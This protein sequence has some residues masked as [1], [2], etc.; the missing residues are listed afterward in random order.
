MMDHLIQG[1]EGFTAAYLD[2]LVIYSST[3]E[4]HLKH[5]HLVFQRLQ[6]AGLTAKPK[7]CQF[8]MQQC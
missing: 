4:E 8:A 6:K 3:W 5:L 2:D 7:K 1:L